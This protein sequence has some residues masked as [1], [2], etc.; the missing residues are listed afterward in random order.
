MGN[1]D[2]LLR[3]EEGAMALPAAKVQSAANMLFSTRTI[4]HDLISLPFIPATLPSITHL[5]IA[6]F[7]HYQNH[8]APLS[9]YTS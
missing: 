9:I 8:F 3:E 7:P 6:S 1:C 2:D 5:S 4:L